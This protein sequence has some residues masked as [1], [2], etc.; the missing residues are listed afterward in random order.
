MANNVYAVC[1]LTLAGI[2]SLTL[3]GI[4]ILIHHSSDVRHQVGPQ[5]KA[6]CNSRK[7]QVVTS[8]SLRPHA[9]LTNTNS[10]CI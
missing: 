5:F 7:D 6:A 4:H 1:H 3:A 9:Q 10:M 8:V 2:H